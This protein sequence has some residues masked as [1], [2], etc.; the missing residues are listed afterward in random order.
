M[1]DSIRVE[2]KGV[3]T[4]VYVGDDDAPKG[5]WLFE[6]LIVQNAPCEDGQRGGEALAGLFYTV[7]IKSFID[8]LP[9]KVPTCQ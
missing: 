9:F 5:M 8:F 4:M 2:A 7:E 3:R 6:D 1:L